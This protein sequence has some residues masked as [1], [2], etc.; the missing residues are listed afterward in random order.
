MFGFSED[1]LARYFY[2]YFSS[3]SSNE[4][5]KEKREKPKKLTSEEQELYDI[6]PSKDHLFCGIM[7]ISKADDNSCQVITIYV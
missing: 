6:T 5:N 2:C 3:T 4:I 1:I 7:S